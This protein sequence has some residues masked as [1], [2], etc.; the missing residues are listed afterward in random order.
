MKDIVNSGECVVD[1]LTTNPCPL[2][3]IIEA[4]RQF[5]QSCPYVKEFGRVNVDWLDKKAKGFAIETV[6]AETVIKR[7]VNGDAVKQF[8][9]LIATREAYS[10]DLLQNV[11]NIAIFERIA[12]WLKEQ[13]LAGNLPE[14]GGGRYAQKIESLTEGY[15]YQTSIDTARYQMQCRLVYDE[16]G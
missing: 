4:V 15:A 9:F 16:E 2:P 7:Y 8:V 1:S 10:A 6:P 14:L 3:P 13:T 12:A 5:M 11:D